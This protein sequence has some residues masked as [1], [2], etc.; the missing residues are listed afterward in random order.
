MSKIKVLTSWF[1]LEA[2]RE[3]S[4]HAS[5]LVSGGLWQPLDIPGL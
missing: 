1:L 4:F 5:L 3:N 2:L